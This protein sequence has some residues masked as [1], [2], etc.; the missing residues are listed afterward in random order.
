MAPMASE[1]QVFED[2]AFLR[3]QNRVMDDMGDASDYSCFDEGGNHI[4]E[5]ED[6]RAEWDV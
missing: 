5:S 2:E 1:E 4:E 3:E 6:E